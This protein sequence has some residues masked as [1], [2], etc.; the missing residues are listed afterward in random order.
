MKS[1]TERIADQILKLSPN[2]KVP[3]KARLG[4]KSFKEFNNLA[5]PKNTTTEKA[6]KDIKLSKVYIADDVIEVVEDTSL[7]PNDVVVE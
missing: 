7:D 1:I 5:I 4:S 3:T 6:L 2:M